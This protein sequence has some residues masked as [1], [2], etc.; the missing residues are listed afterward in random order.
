MA[1]DSLPVV[2]TMISV[3]RWLSRLAKC[4]GT[5]ALSVAEHEAEVL[6]DP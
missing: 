1:D 3:S 4:L 6:S 5:T 2:A